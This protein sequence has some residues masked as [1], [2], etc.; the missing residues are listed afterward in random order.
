M[1]LLLHPPPIF[2][3]SGRLRIQSFL[4][5]V[6]KSVE[7][8]SHLCQPVLNI[9]EKSKSTIWTKF[10]MFI[11]CFFRYTERARALAIQ[12]KD[13]PM[14]PLQ[15]AIYWTEY[16]LRHKGAPYLRTAG[17][18]LPWYQYLLLDVTAVFIFIVICF[19]T[20]MYFILKFIISIFNSMSRNLK[21]KTNWFIV[22]KYF[23]NYLLHSLWYSISHLTLRICFNDGNW[24]YIHKYIIYIQFKIISKLQMMYLLCKFYQLSLF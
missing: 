6:R 23:R 5:N 17:A 16:V 11:I 22:F 13:R 1:S 7:Q 4:G 9:Q 15:T 3:R 18:D 20:I 24:T 19:L 8:V 21:I 10:L 14:T 12:F 2:I